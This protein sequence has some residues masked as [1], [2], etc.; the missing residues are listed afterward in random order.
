MK[1]KQGDIIT[2]VGDEKA[3]VLGV[4]GEVIHISEKDDF[5]KVGY[6]YTEKQLIFL[7]WSFPKEKW[8]PKIGEEYY[9]IN[10]IGEINVLTCKYDNY[11]KRL[12]ENG[13]CF[14]TCEEAELALTRVKKALRGEE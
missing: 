11:D 8:A 14:Q 7:G 6:S 13:N 1:L 10:T 5:E 12:I 9:C 4:C 3:K 2:T